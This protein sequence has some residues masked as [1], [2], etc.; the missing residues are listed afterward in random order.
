MR[1]QAIAHR[2][3]SKAAPE[4]TLAAFSKALENSPDLI[5]LDIRASKDGR[6][7]VIHDPKLDRT[8]N[9]TGPVGEK[10]F[11]QLRELDAGSW[12]SQEFAGE[13]IP[14]LEEALD[15]VKGRVKTLLVEVKEAGLEDQAVALIRER[16][17]AAQ[18]TI[19]SFHH[20]IGVRMPDL[21]PEIP[22]W[23]LVGL[24]HKVEEEEAVRLAD[25][26]AAVNGSGFGVNYTAITPA[27]VKA[28]HA[29]N[30]GINAWTIDNEEEIRAIANLGVD[31]ITSN[32]II[33]LKR[34]LK[35]MG[36]GG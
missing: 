20:K 23:P 3:F 17:M 4:N 21:A 6:L 27:L 31:T 29:A 28:C 15:L 30:I 12:F 36:V 2:G 34:V 22:F 14:V 10:T 35:D 1:I 18:T 8:T 19:I 9:G 16:D 7:M 24:D 33:L 5:E 25:E 26:A 32:D 13:S 11:A